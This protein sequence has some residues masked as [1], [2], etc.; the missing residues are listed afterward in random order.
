M[1]HLANTRG[2]LHVLL[3]CQSIAEGI[4][5]LEDVTLRALPPDPPT[6][7]TTLSICLRSEYIAPIDPLM[8]P[9]AVLISRDTEIFRGSRN[10]TSILSFKVLD[11]RSGASYVVIC[12]IHL[13]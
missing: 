13:H 1:F 9:R 11:D 8:A 5:L 10:V 7:D 3:E 4:S 6:H 2:D 12:E